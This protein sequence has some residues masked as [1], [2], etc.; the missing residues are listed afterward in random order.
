MRGDEGWEAPPR[1]GPEPGAAPVL[2]VEGF[3]GPLDWL[4]ELARAR[5]IDLEKLSILA[6]IEAFEAAM[7]DAL[8]PHAAALT[9]V[10][11]GDW[12]VMAADLAL[13]RSRLLLPA[14][15]SDGRDAAAQAEA[16]R[17]LLVGRAAVGAAAHWLDRRVQLGRDVFARGLSDE[18]NPAR[19][20]RAGDVTALLRACLVVLAL[21]EEEGA[22]YRVPAAPFW[23]VADAV[24]QIRRLLPDIGAGGAKLGAF[25]PSVPAG[26]PDHARHCRMVVASTFVAGLELARG[27]AI[28]LEQEHGFAQIT[29]RRWSIGV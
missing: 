24:M 18:A 16:L 1:A 22:A 17:L 4:V 12:V 21:P 29:A 19:R 20:G 13:L 11:W 7:R 6:L 14:D 15:T 25:M 3:E 23:T 27:G 2:S 8:T 9:L 28:V 26:A 5:R 10:R